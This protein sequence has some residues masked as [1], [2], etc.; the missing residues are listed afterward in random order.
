LKE[1]I[2]IL[3][4][5]SFG[6]CNSK[7]SKSEPI[8]EV[9]G[10][11]ERDLLFDF[12]EPEKE[13]ELTITDFYKNTSACGSLVVP[14]ALIIGTTIDKDLP[15]IVSVLSYCEEGIFEPGQK[16]II[17]PEAEPSLLTS[18]NPL[19]P[20]YFVVTDTIVDG[21]MLSE[22]IIGSENKAVWGSPKLIE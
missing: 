19:N 18:K 14:Y 3:I 11:E 15:K 8:E 20:I 1:L 4:L 9:E 16:V 21:K 7:T 2:L 5:I 12:I 17:I 6:A 22:W 13:F 10:V